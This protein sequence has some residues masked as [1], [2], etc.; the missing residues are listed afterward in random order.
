MTGWVLAVDKGTTWWLISHRFFGEVTRETPE[1]PR[2]FSR[3]EDALKARKIL[4]KNFKLK[5]RGKISP[6]RIYFSPYASKK[7]MHQGCI[8]VDDR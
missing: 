5:H 3:R 6:V 2:V 4:P 8:V 7:R 1:T